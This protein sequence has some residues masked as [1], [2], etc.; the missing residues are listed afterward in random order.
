MESELPEGQG[1]LSGYRALDISDW[2]GAFCG[3]VLADLGTEVIKVE[4]IHGDYS[5]RHGCFYHNARDMERNLLWWAVNANK[6][7]I[8]LSLESEE[9]QVLF[10]KLVGTSDF[11]IESSQPEYMASLGLDYLKLSQ[12]FPSIIVTSIT[13]FG[14]DGP[15]AHYKMCDLTISAMGGLMNI[16]GDDD[17]SPVRISLPQAAYHAGAQAAIGTLIAHHYRQMSGKGQ[18]VDVSME[19]AIIQVLSYAIPDWA[20]AKK[21]WVRAGN[22]QKRVKASYRLIYPC[23]DGFVAYRAATGIMFGPQQARL[24][25]AMDEEGMADD[26]KGIEWPSLSFDEVPQE[27]VDHWEEV[28]TRYF[29]KHTKAELQQE[30][31][32]RDFMLLPIFNASELLEYEQ[33]QERKFWTMVSHPQVNAAVPYPSAIFRS[34]E[35]SPAVRCPPPQLGEG[36]QY[37]YK[38]ILGLSASD[39]T[40]LRQQKVI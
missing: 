27:E 13:P 8:T 34:N 33:L 5:R 39:I 16:C 21:L 9:G 36:N 35:A 29:M 23:K 1:L 32:H 3:K 22:R 15:Y 30:A 25:Q 24:V 12:L 17:R 6:R 14:Q 10:K 11:I 4:P 37:I 40:Y 31:L 2:K 38:D 19:E 7:S 18:H 20:E 26:L 28:L